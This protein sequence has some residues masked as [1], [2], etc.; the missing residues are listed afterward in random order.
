M[1]GPAPDGLM[2]Q[3]RHDIPGTEI[4]AGHYVYAPREPGWTK[5]KGV[6]VV[7]AKQDDGS[8]P[9]VAIGF[10]DPLTKKGKLR[11]QVAIGGITFKTSE[12]GVRFYRVAQWGW[13]V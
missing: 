12:P 1:N 3:V 2:V 11:K 5:G 8:C 9:V 4:K 6:Y 7:T 13:T 10:C